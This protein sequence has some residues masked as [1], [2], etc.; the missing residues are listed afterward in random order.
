MWSTS[1]PISR[2]GLSVAVVLGAAKIGGDVAARL[3]QPSVLGELVAGVLL[4]SLPLS[5]LRELRTDPGL[6]LLARLGVLVL[7]FEVGLDST[8]R[9]VLRV[10][11]ASARVALFGTLGTFL[12]GWFAAWVVMPSAGT[13]VLVFL[14]AAITATSIGISAR[15]LKD[16]GAAR[17]PEAHTILGAAVI[18]DIL[19]LVVLAVVSGAV[20]S[21]GAGGVAPT[22]VLWLVLKTLAFLALALGAGVKLS[23]WL[24]RAT[25]RL[26]SSGALL[27]AGLSLCFV[28]AWASDVMGL[29]PIVGA[30]AAGLALEE[31]HSALF[32]ARGERSLGDLVEP[33]SSWLV[34]IF[35]VLMGMRADFGALRHPETLLLALALVAAAVIGKLTC[36]LGARSGVDGFT[37]A[38]AMMPRG[39]VSLV[40]AS[41]G[42]R[43]RVG[44][45]PLLN[46]QQYSALVSVVLLT[47]L[48]TPLA[49]RWRWARRTG[50]SGVPV[51]GPLTPPDA[52]L[53]GGH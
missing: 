41:L 46:T 7:L 22:A 16:A 5:F 51:S 45:R 37:I 20:I 48:L 3:R 49:L 25:A 21:A 14:A 13:V 38:L 12:C 6:D 33:I 34:P 27:A 11:Y 4:G 15:V 47:T 24:F 29:A 26:R 36:A 30:F 10:G 53:K 23:P 31:S 19:S 9:D 32:V 43:L 2:L 42:L 1:D 18:D 50:T 52:G 35:F 39:E 40:F 17:S 28:L 8:V 44:D